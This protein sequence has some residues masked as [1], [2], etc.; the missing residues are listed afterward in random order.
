MRQMLGRVKKNML[1]QQFE[2]NAQGLAERQF[3]GNPK[4]RQKSKD[5]LRH[6]RRLGMKSDGRSSYKLVE[7]WEVK[8]SREILKIPPRLV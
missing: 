5:Q 2:K 7:A 3:E 6:L 1:Q 4:C 8:R